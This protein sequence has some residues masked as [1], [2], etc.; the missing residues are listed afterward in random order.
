MLFSVMYYASLRT[1][2]SKPIRFAMLLLDP[3][4]PDADP[5][6]FP[7]EDRWSC[8]TLAVELPF[9]VPTVV[10]LAGATDPRSS[11]LAVW[12]TGNG[13][14][15]WG[16]VD[17]QNRFHDF[18]N[19]DTDAGPE[20]PGLFQAHVVGPG[21]IA[22]FVNYSRIGELRIDRLQRPSIDVML[23]GPVKRALRE[24]IRSHLRSVRTRLAPDIRSRVPE[25]QAAL[26]R[27]WVTSLSRILLRAQNYH[28]GGAVLISA[29]DSTLDLTV[30]YPLAYSRLKD[31]L[32]RRGQFVIENDLAYGSIADD[33][34]A[35]KRL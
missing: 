32:E 8:T 30:K 26:R 2:E 3:S 12:D 11:A 27:H 10:K 33:I 13:L 4:D 5:P 1:E 34:D 17:Q 16:L 35:A 23:G 29:D 24:G 14:A 6:E 19:Y 7:P 28:H 20:R 15:I 31:A 21:H 25:Y 18:L 9:D 22:A